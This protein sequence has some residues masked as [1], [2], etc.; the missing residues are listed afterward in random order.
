MAASKDTLNWEVSVGVTFASFMSAVSLF[1]TGILIAQ[2]SS[3]DSTIKVPLLFLIISTFSF[4]FAASIYS[5]AGIEISAGE[6]NL[7][8]KYLEYA[9]NILEFLGL[10]L[11]IFATPLVIGAVTHDKFLRFATIAVSSVGIFLYSRSN[12]SILHKEIKSR[13]TKQWLTLA[14]VGLGLGVELS[15]F[16]TQDF[17]FLD[18]GYLAAVLLALLI[19]MTWHFCRTSNQYDDSTGVV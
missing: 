12:F 4:I 14:I 18:Y 19:G 16:V 7:V 6:L 9:N 10:Y 2:F 15:Q 5:N 17:R 13:L 3:F 8:Q 11:F 1:F